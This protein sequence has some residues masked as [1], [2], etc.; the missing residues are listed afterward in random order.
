MYVCS[1]HFEDEC[2]DSSWMLQFTLTCSD[3]PIQRCLRPGTIPTKFSHKPVKERHFS[4]QCEET[5]DKKEV[6]FSY[7]SEID[8]EYSG[9]I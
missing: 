1:D 2:L 3:R 8:R 5:H 4:K 7:S 9:K 6:C